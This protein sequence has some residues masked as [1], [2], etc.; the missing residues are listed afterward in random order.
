MVDTLL[1]M[2]ADSLVP[3][4]SGH[5]VWVPFSAK[6]TLKNGYGFQGWNSTPPSKPNLSTLG[7]HIVKIPASLAAHIYITLV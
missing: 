5:A 2:A 4:L 1:D 3:V 7:A 6:I